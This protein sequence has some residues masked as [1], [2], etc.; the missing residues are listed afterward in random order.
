MNDSV[1]DDNDGSSGKNIHKYRD[2]GKDDEDD[3]GLCFDMSV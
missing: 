3:E 1:V 2:R